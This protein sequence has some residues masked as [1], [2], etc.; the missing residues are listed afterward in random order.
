MHDFKTFDSRSDEIVDWLSKEFSGIRTG[1]ASPAILDSVQVE[2]YGAKVPLNQV[3]TV[4]VEDPRTL[5]V[6]VWDAGNLA[7]VEKSIRDADLGV[8]ISSDGTGVRVSFPELTSDRRDQLMKL[9][10][11]KLEEARVSLRGAR[12]EA[13]K[14]VDASEEMSEDAKFNAREDLKEKMDTKNAELNQMFELKEK[15]VTQ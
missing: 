5:R 14:G 10:K 3:G 4:G 7:E 12:D 2:S 13:V 11:G 8:N 1:S 15:E 6:S 9:A